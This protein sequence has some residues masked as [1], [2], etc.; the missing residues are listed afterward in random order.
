MAAVVGDAIDIPPGIAVRRDRDVEAR[1]C[2]RA[3]AAS[4]PESAA[5]G[6][7]YTDWITDDRRMGLAKKDAIYMH[8]LPA[9]R[10]SEV[11][12][13]VID[14][15][16]SIVLLGG[17]DLTVY[18]P[19]AQLAFLCHQVVNARKGVVVGLAFVCHDSSVPQ[20][21]VRQNFD[22]STSANSVQNQSTSEPEN[23][24]GG[25]IFNTLP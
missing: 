17:V 19:V 15:P 20:M 3:C 22:V 10:G 7:K 23:T 11:T 2:I 18:Q 4:L 8:C 12:D 5:I 9:D 6:K 16:Q 25:R 14:G 13:E 1:S 24:S 21:R